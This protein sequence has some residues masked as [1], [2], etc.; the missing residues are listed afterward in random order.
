MTPADPYSGQREEILEQRKKQKAATLEHWF[1][2]NLGLGRN[3][4][5][6][7]LWFEPQLEQRLEKS[8]RS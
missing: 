5:Q 4:T 8:H 1:Q 6:G 2:Y 7:E 3:R